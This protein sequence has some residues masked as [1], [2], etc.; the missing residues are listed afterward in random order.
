[1]SGARETVPVCTTLPQ[2]SLSLKFL[3]E[4]LYAVLRARIVINAIFTSY[5]QLHASLSG[6]TDR[7]FPRYD[8]F[9][10]SNLEVS[11]KEML[12]SEIL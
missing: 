3:L 11:K 1:M 5:L 12:K 7:A 10:L 4:I 9:E 8:I 6:Y 2:I